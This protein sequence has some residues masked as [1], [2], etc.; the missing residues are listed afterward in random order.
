MPINGLHPPQTPVRLKLATGLIRSNHAWV[1][2][3]TIL[4]PLLLIPLVF[5]FVA[6][7]SDA[8]LSER[9]AALVKAVQDDSELRQLLWMLAVAVPL[10]V[11]YAIGQRLA[12]MRVDSNGI[13][14]HIPRWLGV[15]F[16]RQSA[17][18]WRLGWGEIQ[19]LQLHAPEVRKM[20]KKVQ[21]IGAYRLELTTSNGQYWLNPF[22]WFDPADDHR[23]RL[24][25]LWRAQKLDVGEVVRRAP[26]F[27]YL[28][29]DEGLDADTQEN[30]ED[31]AFDL[32]SH[33]G[34]LTQLALLTG[35]GGYAII[36]GFFL[37]QWRPLEPMPLLPFV[38][39]FIL[40][41]AIIPRLGQG[42]PRTERLAVG[43]LTI[44][45]LTSA[46]Y[47]GLLR[48]NAA[49][50]EPQLIQYQASGPG[51]FTAPSDLFPEIDLTG[52][53]VPEYW[54]EYPAGSEHEFRLLRGEPGF[55]QLDLGHFYGKTRGFYGQ[56]Q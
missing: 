33:K 36:D 31:T 10:L 53:D 52:T 14:C 39:V 43:A 45:A 22:S 44:A 35:A 20:A 25:E 17:G 5:L 7:E 23:L 51:T 37:G 46:V 38:L 3:G 54:E 13:E 12:W 8:T 4:V 42:A 1:V 56:Q 32:A 27:D 28:N 30:R 9:F 47:P 19:G 26:L 24:G 6:P 41:L 50:A 16:M 15:G 48:L 11:V 21:L 2:I 29:P 40:A 55:I 18:H 34:M 49:T